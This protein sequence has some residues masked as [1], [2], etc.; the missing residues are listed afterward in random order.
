MVSVPE[1][2]S[3]T[4]E[5]IPLSLP[6]GHVTCHVTMTHARRRGCSMCPVSNINRYDIKNENTGTS[7]P[8]GGT[9]WNATYL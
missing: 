6:P 2:M 3:F 4:L 1:A 9:L 7:P 8:N 5:L